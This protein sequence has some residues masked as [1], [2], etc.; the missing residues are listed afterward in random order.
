MPVCGIVVKL[1]HEKYN[2]RRVRIA[3]PLEHRD[4]RYRPV[5]VFRELSHARNKVMK[6]HVPVIYGGR[7]GGVRE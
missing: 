6:Q 5:N 2:V 7:E 4:S 3:N 1:C